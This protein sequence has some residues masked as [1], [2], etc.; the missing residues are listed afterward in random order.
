VTVEALPE[1][2]PVWGGAENPT[3][4][5][6]GPFIRFFARAAFGGGDAF[7]R[8]PGWIAAAC[9]ANPP[10]PGGAA[11][12]LPGQQGLAR[13]R[14]ALKNGV[15]LYPGVMDALT[16]WAKKLNVAAPHAVGA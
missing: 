14:A 2:V 8:E 7:V 9:R 13:K 15:S 4:W 11:V 16:P 6:S 10:V 1:G 3:G 5:G 12:R